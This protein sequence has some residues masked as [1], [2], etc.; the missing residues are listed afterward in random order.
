MH[1]I[2]CIMM[3]SG[4]TSWAGLSKLQALSM[5]ESG[6]NDAAI[7]QAGEVS[8]YQ[9]KPWIWR[10]YSQSKAYRDAHESSAV[11]IKYLS[12]LEETFRKRARREPTDFDLY[13]LWNAGP[14]YYSK[15]G[16]SPSRID[17]VIRNRAR[18][19]NNLRRMEDSH[20]RPAKMGV[21]KS[22]LAPPM[23]VSPE[24]LALLRPLPPLGEPGLKAVPSISPDAPMT[25]GA[26]SLPV[27]A[28]SGGILAVGAVR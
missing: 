24:F 3:L 22:S 16:F 21:A 20:G 11:A 9:I 19:F 6:D 15:C 25:S 23:G 7:G 4:T 26:Q 14:A 10:G 8:R 27:L 1:K 12:D 5:I 13:V 17:P 28:A 2:L 18:R